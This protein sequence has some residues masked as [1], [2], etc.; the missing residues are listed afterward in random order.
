MPART[1]VALS[2]LV[3]ACGTGDKRP[4]RPPAAVMTADSTQVPAT[5]P[6]HATDSAPVS[7]IDDARLTIAG[8][9]PGQDES[10]VRSLLGTPLTESEPESSEV[11]SQPLRKLSYPDLIVELV[12]R[13]VS[14]VTCLG[15]ACATPDG[16]R[17]GDPRSKIEITYGHGRQSP[18]GL[19]TYRDRSSDCGM[20]FSLYRDTI[21][22]FKLWCDE[23]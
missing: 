17:V 20:T 18:E 4:E 9:A 23:S 21:G 22:T 6:G 14:A 1:K 5:A 12:G 19:L 8:I 13:R 3:L 15:P 7:S 16:I 10:R 2:V 11:L